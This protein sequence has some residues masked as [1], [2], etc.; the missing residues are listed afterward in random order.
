MALL[1]STNR[2]AQEEIL[3]GLI[4][5]SL[6]HS[7]QSTQTLIQALDH[8]R[9]RDDLDVVLTGFYESRSPYQPEFGLAW[10]R[11][12]DGSASYLHPGFLPQNA[13]MIGGL[14]YHVYSDRWSIHT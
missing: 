14:V 13:L 12:K 2:C 8:L 1:I 6:E 10:F 5:V 9:A 11:K 7:G 4:K 3:G